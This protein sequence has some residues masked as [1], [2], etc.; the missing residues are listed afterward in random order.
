MCMDTSEAEARDRED[1]KRLMAGQD[2][3]LNDLMAR[4][5][6]PVFQFLY[7]L[8][9]NEDDANDLAQETFARV[10]RARTSFRL[11]QRFT[12][13][14]FTISANL[15][16]NQ[17]RWRARH[18][19]VSIDAAQD[20]SGQTIASTLPTGDPSPGDQ[21]IANERAEAVRSAVS[22]LPE[23]LREAIVLCEW[24][25]RTIVEAA[26]ILGATAKAVESRLYRARQRLRAQ[27]KQWL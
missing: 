18:P 19:N 26:A 22:A 13:W 17:F 21:V 10:Y 12:T 14:L 23:D 9:G 27:L 15:A 16:R 24:E 1:M 7:R 20:H 25:E 2:T 3:A 8:L 6:S 11:D 5:A 4:H